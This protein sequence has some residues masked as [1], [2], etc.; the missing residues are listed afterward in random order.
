MSLFMPDFLD[1]LL[2]AQGQYGFDPFFAAPY[3]T[4]K[5]VVFSLVL[6]SSNKIQIIQYR[7]LTC[8]VSR[9]GS[10]LARV[11]LKGIYGG[12]HKRWSM[13]FNSIHT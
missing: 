10:M 13:W 2:G 9:L 3:T 4:G 6:A 11:K 1:P 8:E 7:S 12:S 5:P